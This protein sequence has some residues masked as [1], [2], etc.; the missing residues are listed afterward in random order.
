M[1]LGSLIQVGKANT[2]SQKFLEPIITL[3]HVLE[4][5]LTN[6]MP[7]VAI[8]RQLLQG[9][10]HQHGQRQ[11]EHVS[12]RQVLILLLQNLIRQIPAVA[13]LHVRIKR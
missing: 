6:P 8:L 10:T 13:L 12:L 1:P 7:L 11:R 4:V 2:Y 5:S 3:R 9:T